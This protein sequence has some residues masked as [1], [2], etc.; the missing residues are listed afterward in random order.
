MVCEGDANVWMLAA[1]AV[2][3]PGCTTGVEGLL[4]DRPV[5]SYVPEPGIEFLN[6]ADAVSYNVASADRVFEKSM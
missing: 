5:Y 3:H 2:L 6:Q 4:L 1:E